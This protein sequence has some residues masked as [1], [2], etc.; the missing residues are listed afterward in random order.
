MK[1][2]ASNLV[3]SL[4]CAALA[5]ALSGAQAQDPIA[6][7]KKANTAEAITNAKQIG[8]A[9]LEFE[10][11]YGAYPSEKTLADVEEATRV[12]LPGGEKSSNALLRQLFAAD[13]TNNEAIFYAN[14]TG[15]MKGGEQPDPAKALGKGRNAFAYISG[16]SSAG[17]PMRPLLVCPLIPG[18]TKFDPTPFGGKAI[19]LRLDLSVLA[20]PIEEDGRVLMGGVELLSK[21]HEIWKGLDGKAPDIR[22]PD[23]AAEG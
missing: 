18:T 23:L 17:N 3:P 11:E 5:F 14:L 15:V 22:Y 7:L 8:L 10:T 12:K 21:K 20:L 4:I 9:L 2:P 6:A 16:L 1:H 13:I 19:I